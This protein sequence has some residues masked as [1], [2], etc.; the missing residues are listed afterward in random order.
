MT[1]PAGLSRTDDRLAKTVSHEYRVPLYL[2]CLVRVSVRFS[3][4][5]RTT[6]ILVLCAR[7]NYS[8]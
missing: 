4:A 2:N 8:F 6:I 1:W 5:L 3:M 7:S